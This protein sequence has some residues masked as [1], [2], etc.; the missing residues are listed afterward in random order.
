MIAEFHRPQ[1][2]EEALQLLSREQIIALPF[3]RG[4]SLAGMR[5]QTYAFVDLQDLGLDQ[6][7]RQ[8]GQARVGSQ[9]TLQGLSE[10]SG[11]PIA[12][13]NA[14]RHE[15]SYNLRQTRTVADA[16]FGADGRSPFA[17]VLLALGAALTILPGE[18]KIG[19]SDFFA[20]EFEQMRGR[21]ITEIALP[22]SVRVAYEYVARTPA[23]FPIVCAGLAQWPSGRTRVALGGYGSRPVLVMDGP[24]PDGAEAAASSAYEE[25]GD[26][27]ASAAYRSE[28]AGILVRRC[29]ESLKD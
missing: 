13:V 20:M 15:Y 10:Y 18:E 4:K 17:T 1:T 22:L 21:L 16:L 9:V 28:I 25:A 5:P 26:E 11:L 27:W 12:L 8:G 23:D 14:I 24:E 19:L 29:L 3:E 7:E 6:I 2:I